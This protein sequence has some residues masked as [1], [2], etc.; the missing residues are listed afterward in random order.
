MAGQLEQARRAAAEYVEQLRPQYEQAML[1]TFDDSVLLAQR[2][3]ADR[4]R[5][6]AAIDNLRVGANTSLL[7]GLHYAIRELSSRGERPVLLL[8]TDG[9]D[10]ASFH[11]RHEVHALLDRRPDLTIWIE[12]LHTELST[13]PGA[14]RATR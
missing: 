3:T 9:V 1:L 10:S 4:Q 11:E 13:N 5:L 8:L 14:R 7:D 12:V 2:P 6:I